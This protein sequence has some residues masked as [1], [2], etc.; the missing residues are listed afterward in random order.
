MSAHAGRMDKNQ[1]GWRRITVHHSAEVHPPDLDGTQASSA[2]AVRSIQKAHIDGKETGWGDIGYHFLVDPYGR[3]FQGRD[4]AWQGAH[5]KG[6][7]N[8]Q[9]IGVCLLGNFEEERPTQAALAA[10]EKLLDDLRQ[11]HGIAR[12]RVLVH[13]DLKK[14]ECPGRHLLPWVRQ[15]AGG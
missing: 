15:Y 4:L 9:N 8:V 10:L 5:A 1:G 14:T 2:A 11:Q 12:S 6:N 3:V 13:G 7:N